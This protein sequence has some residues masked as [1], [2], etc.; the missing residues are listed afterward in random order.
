MKSLLLQLPRAFIKSQFHFAQANSTAESQSFVSLGSQKLS[1]PGKRRYAEIN[2]RGKQTNQERI[3]RDGLCPRD[4]LP[5]VISL[6]H[7]GLREEVCR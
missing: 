1:F 5:P 2:T 6:V 7:A 3:L 4:R